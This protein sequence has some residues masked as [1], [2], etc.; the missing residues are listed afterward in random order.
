MNF[1]HCPQVLEQA[2]FLNDLNIGVRKRVIPRVKGIRL[3]AVNQ[4]SVF[5]AVRD[6]CLA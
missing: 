5:R 6:M 2:V 1:I 3:K 4:I